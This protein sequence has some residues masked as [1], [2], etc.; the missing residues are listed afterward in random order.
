MNP[1]RSKMKLQFASA[2]AFGLLAVGLVAVN[3]LAGLMPVR[4]DITE[5]G[6]YTL[7]EGTLN[8]LNNLE[9]PVTLKFFF[10]E[11]L[12]ELPVSSKIHARKVRELLEEYVS[13][14]NGK[15]SLEV[16]DP[17]PDSDEEEWAIRYGLQGARLPTG[18]RMFLGMVALSG[19]QETVIPFFDSRREKFLEYDISENITRVNQTKK[20]KIALVSYLPMTGQMDPRTGRRQG[21]WALVG[22]MRKLFDVDTIFPDDL[23]EI[24]ESVSLLM[25]VHPRKVTDTIAYALDQYLMRGGRMIVFTDPYSRLDTGNPRTMNSQFSSNLAPLFKAWKIKFDHEQV[26]ADLSLATR[27]NTQQAGVV[28]YPVWLTFREGYINRDSVITSQLEQVTMADAGAFSTEEGFKLSFTPLLTSST[29]AGE[30]DRISVRMS[31]PLALTKIVKPDGKTRVL[32]AL[33]TGK[34]D[35]AFPDGAPPP[36]TE[37]DQ[38][39]KEVIRDIERK[40]PHLSQAAKESTVLLVGDSDFIHDR[41]S[42]RAI[43]FFGQTV[44]QPINDN[45]SFVLNS[46]EALIGSQDL[47]HIRSRGQISRPFT[48]V[49]ELQ[50][51]AQRRYKEQEEE[52]SDSLEE[53]RNRLE[54][55]ESQKKDA[56][57]A[58]LSPAQLA[59]IQQFRL[60]EART[61]RELREVR[62]VLRQDIET[63]GNVLLLFN[64]LAVPLL[65]V[66]VGFTVILRRSRR[67]GGRT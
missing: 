61:K 42:V 18:N 5:E 19:G 8:I 25:V 10:N 26:V 31:Q 1:Q 48:K 7:S 50:V 58:L 4:L 54:A 49:S 6:L 45:M 22:E 13:R 29:N 9:E 67:S 35:S 2:A 16:V 65:V 55:L 66:M 27:V 21:E 28:D 36:P 34:F 64:L 20:K 32:A 47:I 17:K 52:L 14:S 33:V 44:Y 63:L 57:N 15:V 30:V 46:V 40:L 3:V 41:F 59:E 37:K 62:K 60:E 23:A 38:K 51:S 24:P 12:G 39:G 11:S 56:K 43:N 53:V